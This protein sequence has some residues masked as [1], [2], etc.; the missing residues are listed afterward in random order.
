MGRNVSKRQVHVKS[1]IISIEGVFWQCTRNYTAE[2]SLTVALRHYK[3]NKHCRV[4]ILK[5]LGDFNRKAC[6][7]NNN[8]REKHEQCRPHFVGM[9][10][11]SQSGFST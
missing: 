11:S 9:F 8:S 5:K 1:N 3:K 4:F 10:K 7:G 6:M 2:I